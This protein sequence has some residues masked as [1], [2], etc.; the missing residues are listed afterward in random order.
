[1]YIKI[2]YTLN[3]GKQVKRAYY[4]VNQDIYN[5]L[6]DL[7]KSDYRTARLYDAFFG[8]YKTEAQYSKDDI[9]AYKDAVEKRD[10]E[11]TSQYNFNTYKGHYR[12]TAVQLRF[13]TSLRLVPSSKFHPRKGKP[14]WLIFTMI[15]QP[16]LPQSS[17]IL[18]RHTARWLLPQHRIPSKHRIPICQAI[19]IQA[20]LPMPPE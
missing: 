19:I 14:F 8:K 15:Y 1:M 18:P 9:K 7:D 2:V 13:I 11:Y 6:L 20:A 3:D 16:C 12:T 10:L 17:I 5:M 4:G